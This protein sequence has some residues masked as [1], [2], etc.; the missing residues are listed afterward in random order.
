MAD[1]FN[2]FPNIV[3]LDLSNNHIA[4][5][6]EF[7]L[8]ANKKL[9]TVILNSNQLASI[10]SL[11]EFDDNVLQFLSARHNKLLSVD[12]S[13]LDNLSVLDLKDNHLDENGLTSC[14]NYGRSL[15]EVN[16]DS[17][18]IE[19]IDNSM[20]AN[21]M[22]IRQMSLGKN[23]ISSIEPGAFD[24]LV[25]LQ[26]LDLSDNPASDYITNSWH[27]CHSLNHKTLNVQQNGG[28]VKKD[29]KV[30]A[31]TDDYCNIKEPCNPDCIESLCDN[32]GGHLKCEGSIDDLFCELKDTNF[33]SISFLFPK[34]SEILPVENFYEA[35]SNSY[36]REFNQIN[37]KSNMTKYLKDLKLYGTKFDL[38]KLETHVGLRTES[39]TVFADTVYMSKSIE[40]VFY[41]L[42]V[43]ARV[44]SVSE[45]IW[46]NMTHKQFFSTFEADQPVDNWANVE[47]IITDVG[48][49]S[50]AIR[51]LGFIEVQQAI[52]LSTALPQENLCSPRIFDVS[53]YETEHNTPPAIFFDRAQINLLRLAV[54]TLAST[55]SNPTLALN[56]ADHVLQKTSNPAIVADKKAYIVAQK[57]I[58]DKEILTSHTRNV[59]FYSTKVI[60]D[61][62]QVMYDRMSDYARN[63]TNLMNKLDAALGRMTDM[64]RNFEDARLMRELYFEM[65]LMTLEEIWNSTDSSWHWSFNGSRNM[66]SSIQDSMQRNQEEMFAME[67]RDL[68]E[69]LARA[70]DTVVSDQAVVEMFRAE[71]ERYS[72]EAQMSLELQRSELA[73]TNLQGDRVKIEKENFDR[74]KC[75]SKETP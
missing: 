38:A 55:R 29:Y 2:L 63:E 13:T 57:L 67:E 71:I 44:V 39:V 64:N 21:Q 33:K 1:G 50:F 43:R 9:E 17:N 4:P 62:A 14:L 41:R 54:R 53:Q 59:P 34:D 11:F 32:D 18:M 23:N 73:Q 10:P 48:D 16:L 6:D 24:R 69:M 65:E 47:E 70:R 37:G 36:F 28:K 22:E 8:E 46:M 75:Q 40:P 27:F 49:T 45:D 15:H 12:C 7:A 3:Y 25:S 72:E 5:I 31:F 52:T 20:F 19:R 30:D 26:F 60:K 35:E 61:L 58:R 68:E 74:A 56:M 66:E 42:S 51:K